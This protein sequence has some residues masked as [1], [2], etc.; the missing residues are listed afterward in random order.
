MSK[1]IIFSGRVQG[2]GFRWHVQR[3]AQET[4]IDGWV[5]NLEDGTVLVICQGELAKIEQ[6]ILACKKGNGFSQ[7]K[8]ILVEEVPGPVSRGFEILD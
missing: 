6:F 8:D 2:V 7:V 1:K 5:K 4:G 3:C